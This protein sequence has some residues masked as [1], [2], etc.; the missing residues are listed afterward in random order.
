[1]QS[2]ILLVTGTLM[3]NKSLKQERNIKSFQIEGFMRSLI[4]IASNGPFEMFLN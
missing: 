2:N 3:G 4:P 1:M